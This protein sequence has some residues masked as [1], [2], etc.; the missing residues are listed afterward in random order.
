MQVLRDGIFTIVT[1]SDA[2]LDDGESYS[3]ESTFLL[4]GTE[5]VRTWYS[6]SPVGWLALDEHV[7]LRDTLDKLIFDFFSPTLN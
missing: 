1:T 4:M 5:D 7:D 2:I 6:W 3:A